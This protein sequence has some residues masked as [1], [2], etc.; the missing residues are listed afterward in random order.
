MNNPENT[1]PESTN[2]MKPADT[3]PI[4]FEKIVGIMFKIRKKIRDSQ[5][6]FYKEFNL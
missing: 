1:N 4:F 5:P 2:L 6:E 3:N